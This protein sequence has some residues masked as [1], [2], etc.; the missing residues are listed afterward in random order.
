MVLF[1]DFLI[2]SNNQ[3]VS[4]LILRG[5]FISKIFL[6]VDG[7][8]PSTLVGP[9]PLPRPLPWAP[10]PGT[11]RRGP[12]RLLLTQRDLLLVPC[13][14]DPQRTSAPLRTS[15]GVPG[16]SVPSRTRVLSPVKVSTSQTPGLSCRTRT[17]DV[18][19][20]RRCH[21]WTGTGV[22]RRPHSR[23][24]PSLSTCSPAQGHS[25]PVATPDVGLETNFLRVG[26]DALRAS[27]VP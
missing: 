17:G 24:T 14:S 18:G 4:K 15:T 12:S 25:A 26:S 23:L 13:G 21:S 11:H 5:K 3:K 2:K 22:D 9:H 7:L 27:R 1:L 16:P 20:P 10:V 19:I 6:L 8:P